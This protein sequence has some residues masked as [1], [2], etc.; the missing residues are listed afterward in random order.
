MDNIGFMVAREEF[1]AIE[2]A[3]NSSIEEGFLQKWMKSKENV[4]S[5]VLNNKLIFIEE[6]DSQRL[7]NIIVNYKKTINNGRGA[8]LFLTLNNVNKAKFFDDLT[9]KYSRCIL[10]IGFNPKEMLVNSY[11]TQIYELK[12]NY[13]K[14]SDCSNEEIDNFEYIKLFTSKITNKIS[15]LNDKTILI[16]LEEENIDKKF[17]LS[18]KY[19]EYLP[20]WIQKMIHIEEDNER[21]NINEKI[22]LIPEFLS[23]NNEN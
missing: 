20:R 22:K 21:N 19:K 5:H 14:T 8:F 12:K 23:Q 1:I 2:F 13:N 11:K 3:F 9:G 18:Y 4:F 6:N 10:F 17:F 7:S 15:D 16:I